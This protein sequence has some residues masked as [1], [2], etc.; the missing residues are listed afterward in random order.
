MNEESIF[1]EAI[2][3]SDADQRRAYLDQA[4]QDNAELRSQVEGLLRASGEAGSFFDH[5]P[6]GLMATVDVASDGGDMLKSGPATSVL[7]FLAPCDTPGRIG[8]LIGKVGEYEIIEVVGQGGM[9]I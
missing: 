1:A 8:K 9:G 6:D 4:C 3:L 7:P 5:P 2:K